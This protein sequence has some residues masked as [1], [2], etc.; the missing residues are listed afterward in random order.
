MF[1]SSTKGLF[2]GYEKND[3]K[4]NFFKKRYY[5]DSQENS[6]ACIVLRSTTAL[7]V[8]LNNKPYI[9]RLTENTLIQ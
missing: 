4:V 7:V 5:F 8:N 3:A 1:P 6:K 9:L 2:K